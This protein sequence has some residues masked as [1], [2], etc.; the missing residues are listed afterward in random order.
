MRGGGPRSQRAP[1][2][3][4]L[5]LLLLLLPPRPLRGGR[6]CRLLLLL[7]VLLPCISP[8]QRR[9]ANRAAYHRSQPAR[10][11]PRCVP[12][13]PMW[14]WGKQRRRQ[15]GLRHPRAPLLR[16]PPTRNLRQCQR[17]TWRDLP[18]RGRQAGARCTGPCAAAAAAASA[19]CRTA[20]AAQ[21]ARALGGCARQRHGRELP[22]RL[23]PQPRQ[24][25]PLLLRP[26]LALLL[27]Q[28]LPLAGLMLQGPASKHKRKV[29]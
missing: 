17:L 4:L 28:P 13:R 20:W 25:L 2:C 9:G 11:G 14:L 19:V 7:L 1:A 26:L 21:L 24:P 8:P 15:T 10:A 18:A 23:G 16:L 3:Q 27:L 29:K 6:G 22:R 5:P 12:L